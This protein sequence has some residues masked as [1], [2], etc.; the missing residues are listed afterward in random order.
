MAGL[1]PFWA[2]KRLFLA[3]TVP[4]MQDTLA[5]DMWPSRTEQGRQTGHTLH[6][7]MQICNAFFT[8]SVQRMELTP[9]L[10][11]DRVHAF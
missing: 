11:L 10:L 2:K 7:V 9:L 6:T 3:K 5:I 8:V 4:I 1:G